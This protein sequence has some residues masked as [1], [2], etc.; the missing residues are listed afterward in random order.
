MTN[1]SDLS[2]ADA[3]S[4]VHLAVIVFNVFGLFA[5]PLGGAL[6]WRCVRV[7]WWRWLHLASMALVAL[8]AVA[9]QAC[10]LTVLQ[11]GLAGA[12]NSDTPLIMGFVNRMIF[13]PLPFWAFAALYV[14]LL[15]YVILL[16]RF[17]PV[18]QRPPSAPTALPD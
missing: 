13:W 5:I 9:G 6:R 7:R 15:L 1:H 10:F 18:E 4:I 11:E 14:V 8:Q 17:V 2:G 12:G 3:V 16:F